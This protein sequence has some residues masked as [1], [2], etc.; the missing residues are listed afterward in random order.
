M[1]YK[2][3]EATLQPSGCGKIQH[4]WSTGTSPSSLPHSNTPRTCLPPGLISA[5]SSEPL[6]GWASFPT[7][8]SSDHH[9][10]NFNSCSH[11]SFPRPSKQVGG[12][13]GLN[14]LAKHKSTASQA[15]KHGKSQAIIQSYVVQEQLQGEHFPSLPGNPASKMLPLP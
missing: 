14:F 6:K 15:P 12:N 7:R 4:C 5:C 11:L 2:D 3:N 1:Y 8:P 10:R 13:P 9:I